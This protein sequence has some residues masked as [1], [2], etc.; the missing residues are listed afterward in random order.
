MHLMRLHHNL[1]VRASRAH[2]PVD[3]ACQ[4][5]AIVQWQTVYIQ[6]ALDH[7]AA[8]GRRPDPADVARLSPLGHPPINLNG[9]YL[10]HQPPA[11]RSA[12]PPPP[13]QLTT[14]AFRILSEGLSRCLFKEVPCAAD[15]VAVGHD[16]DRA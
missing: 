7:L 16:L 15:E 1:I 3:P 8:T 12:P 4:R 6:A 5:H 9:R 11:R 14:Y 13:S 10:T 2:P